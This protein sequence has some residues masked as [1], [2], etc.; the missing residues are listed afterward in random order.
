MTVFPPF[1]CCEKCLCDPSCA[2]TFSLKQNTGG[3]FGTDDSSGW[4]GGLLCTGKCLFEANRTERYCIRMTFSTAIHTY[5]NPQRCASACQFPWWDLQKVFIK[6][7]IYLSIHL[8]LV[9]KTYATCGWWWGCV[10]LF[11]QWDQLDNCLISQCHASMYVFKNFP[12]H[13]VRWFYCLC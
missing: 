6:F 9:R 11:Q 2:I 8:S 5:V 10:E 12:S 13:L 7:S 1:R 3:L 4:N